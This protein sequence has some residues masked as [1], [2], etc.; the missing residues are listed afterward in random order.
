MA[1]DRIGTSSPLNH[2]NER[3]AGKIID[4]SLADGWV[5]IA[6]PTTMGTVSHLAGAGAGEEVD[7]R[8]DVWSL[9][10][11]EILSP[12]NF[13]SPGPPAIIHSILTAKPSG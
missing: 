6:D 12:A 5:K 10:V 1:G 7:Q 13:P 3:W 9:G 11:G 8:P 4:F 2:G